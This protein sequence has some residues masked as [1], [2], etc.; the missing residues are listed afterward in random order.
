MKE[1]II[2]KAVVGSKLYGTHSALSDTDIKGI[3]LPDLHDLILGKAPKHYTL[4]TS[5]SLDKNTFND[6]DET[7]YSLQYFL[8]LLT[9]GET[10][11]MDLFFSISNSECVL[12]N[13]YIWSENFNE[14]LNNCITK[15][16]RSYL[17]YCKSQAQKYSIKG[18]KL[19]N[20]NAFKSFCEKYLNEKDAN[21]APL[22]Y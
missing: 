14:I 13:D 18:D 21:G 9:K 8:E 22:P 5:S 20:Y 2:Y 6:V 16:C 1:R 4:T 7:Y 15:N 17:S 3:F 10:N 19:K 11:A 12:K